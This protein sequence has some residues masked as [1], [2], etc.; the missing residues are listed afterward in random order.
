MGNNAHDWCHEHLNYKEMRE[1]RKSYYSRRS[2]E[3]S[4]DQS[5]EFNLGVILRESG[6][7]LAEG[8]LYLGFVFPHGSARKHAFEPAEDE[9]NEWE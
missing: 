6:L 4:L 1:I 5:R 3:P 7:G 8:L 2:K 9:E